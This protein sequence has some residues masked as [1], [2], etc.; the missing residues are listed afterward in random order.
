MP[1]PSNLAEAAEMLKDIKHWT[2]RTRNRSGERVGYECVCAPLWGFKFLSA[3]NR[4]HSTTT[5]LDGLDPAVGHT[6]IIGCEIRNKRGWYVTPIEL[7]NSAIG[8]DSNF[9]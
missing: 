1:Q 6:D 4:Q 2:I 9:V 7:S 5:Y 3:G 8:I